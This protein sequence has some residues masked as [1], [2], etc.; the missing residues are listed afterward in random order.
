AVEMLHLLGMAVLDDWWRGALAGQ[1]LIAAFAPATAALVAATA[2]RWGSPP[3]AWFAAV[4]YLTTSWVFRL[5][6]FPFVEGP[7]CCYHA[8]LVLVAA[9]AWSGPSGAPAVGHRPWPPWLFAGLLAGGAMAC[10]YPG[11]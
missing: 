1:L 5:G 10:K 4:V 6:T 8:A 7:L 9:T 3:A 2:L 11:L